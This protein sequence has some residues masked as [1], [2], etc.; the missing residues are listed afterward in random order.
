MILEMLSVSLEQLRLL[1][2][3]HCQLA[4]H[5]EILTRGVVRDGRSECPKA[6]QGLRS[7]CRWCFFVIAQNSAE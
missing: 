7:L 4:R 5:L 6:C 3:A 2:K 1:T